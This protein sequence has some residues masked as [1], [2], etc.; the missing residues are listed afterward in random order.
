MS[1]DYLVENLSRQKAL[2]GYALLHA[3]EPAFPPQDWAAILAPESQWTC[4]AAEDPGDYIRGL[5]VY[6][7]GKHPLVGALM[8]VP[9]FIAA[10][11]VDD[12]KIA[13][14][15]F[16]SLRKKALRCNYLRVW[17][18]V[19]KSLVHINDEYVFSGWDHGLMYRMASDSSPALL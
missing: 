18:E 14:L 17:S 4:I 2:S 10:S 8:D 9:I 7:V 13:E 3:V 6:R 11:V 15:L 1:S 16:S 12:A 19:P 5:V